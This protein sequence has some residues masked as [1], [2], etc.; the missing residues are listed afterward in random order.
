[1]LTC[2]TICP[3]KTSKSLKSVQKRQKHKKTQNAEMKVEVLGYQMSPKS[4]RESERF[5]S[6]S[7]AKLQLW[8]A[9][10]GSIFTDPRR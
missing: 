4:N 5:K 3:L 2:V 8:F 10:F 9:T 1:M 6:Y 7:H